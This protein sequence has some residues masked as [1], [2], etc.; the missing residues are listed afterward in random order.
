MYGQFYFPRKMKTKHL[1]FFLL[2]TNNNNAQ[3]QCTEGKIV[4]KSNRRATNGECIGRP[5]GNQKCAVACNGK[6][7]LCSFAN[8][9][10]NISYIMQKCTHSTRHSQTSKRSIHTCIVQHSLHFPRCRLCLNSL[11]RHESRVASHIGTARRVLY[12]SHYSTRYSTYG[13]RIAVAGSARAQPLNK[14]V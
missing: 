13:K 10:D 11:C 14:G 7:A 9:F 4:N 3:R 1:S 2:A 6:N 12:Y 8:K 5:N